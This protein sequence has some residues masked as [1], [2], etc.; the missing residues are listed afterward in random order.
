[1]LY[2]HNTWAWCPQKLED[3]PKLE[4]EWSWTTM[5][6]LGTKSGFSGRAA[7]VLNCWD[8][9]QSP[10]SGFCYK[11]PV[12]LLYIFFRDRVFLFNTGCPGT[13]SVDQAGLELRNLPAS[14]CASRVL[15]LKACA[16]TPGCLSYIFISIIYLQY[17]L[18]GYYW[19]QWLSQ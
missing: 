18:G 15:G 3:P 9:V 12:P 14:D 1:M 2:L 13:H 7:S 10:S 19:T 4:C 6:V 11:F 5:W 8:N 17:F 16:T